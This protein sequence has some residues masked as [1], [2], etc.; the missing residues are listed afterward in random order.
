MSGP[1]EVERLMT[2]GVEGMRA[3]MMRPRCLAKS[4]WVLDSNYALL[5]RVHEEMDELK[6]ACVHAR[7]ATEA[8]GPTSDITLRCLADVDA[9]GSDVKNFTTMLIDPRRIESIRARR[10]A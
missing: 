5:R 8:F 6:E 4:S 9:E 7:H 2:L 1:D 10:V 3:K